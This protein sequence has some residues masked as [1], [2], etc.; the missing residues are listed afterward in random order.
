MQEEQAQK[1][2]A[3]DAPVQEEQVQITQQE[4]DPCS[5][6]VCQAKMSERQFLLK[7]L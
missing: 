1:E 5:I 7:W 6:M 3:Q 2:P 4:Q